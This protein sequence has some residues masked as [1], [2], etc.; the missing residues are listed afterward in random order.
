MDPGA[1]GGHSPQAPLWK[2]GSALPSA[3]RHA[4][5]RRVLLWNKRICF[6]WT[7]SL[8]ARDVEYCWK[9]ALSLPAR[10]SLA[11][12]SKKP[13]YIAESFRPTC[14][15]PLHPLSKSRAWKW[16]CSFP[17]VKGKHVFLCLKKKQ[18]PRAKT[19]LYCFVFSSTVG[20][21]IWAFCTRTCRLA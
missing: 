14:A 15:L 13:T 18:P 3:P 8:P 6:N 21:K 17:P 1:P 10:L 20:N 7:P 4:A 2:R 9:A 12:Q 19:Y 5:A 16:M 11:E